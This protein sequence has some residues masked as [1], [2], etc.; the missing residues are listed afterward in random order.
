M[1]RLMAR[2]TDWA[3]VNGRDVLPI[4]QKVAV[5]VEYLKK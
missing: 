5:D 2:L 1:H 3:Q 4:P